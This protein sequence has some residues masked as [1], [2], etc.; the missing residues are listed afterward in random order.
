VSH[1]MFCSVMGVVP[2]LKR[3]QIFREKDFMIFSYERMVQ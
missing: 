2:G 3:G 1:S